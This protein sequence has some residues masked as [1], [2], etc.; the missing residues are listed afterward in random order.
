MRR[1]IAIALTG[2]LSACALLPTD[3]GIKAVEAEDEFTLDEGQRA[4]VL[5]SRVSVEFMGVPVDERCPIEALCVSPGN[6]IVR[7]RV[8]QPGHEPATF[9][10][11]TDSPD[12]FAGYHDHAIV[13]RQLLPARSISDRDPDYHARLV[14]GTL[15]TIDQ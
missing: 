1:L 2:V 14:V 8:S 11:R 13:L 3:G 9:D 4:V 6:A 7:V 10:L 12:A 15:F 5:G